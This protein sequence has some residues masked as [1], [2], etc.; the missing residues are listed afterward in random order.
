MESIAY[1]FLMLLGL[2]KAESSE[3][4]QTVTFGNLGDYQ[5]GDRS[6]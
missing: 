3:S 2:L 5:F 4:H 1:R 6:C